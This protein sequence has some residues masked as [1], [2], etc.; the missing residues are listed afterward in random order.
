[1]KIFTIILSLLL[2]AAFM[3]GQSQAQTVAQPKVKSCV[4][5]STSIPLRDIT[6][7]TPL[8]RMDEN[9]PHDDIYEGRE[10]P[11][12]DIALP[13]G[14]DPAWQKDKG[15]VGGKAPTINFEAL[16]NSDNS[17][18]SVRPPD[19]DG[20]VGPNHYFAMCNN[21]F[22]IFDRE[23]NTLLGP[24]GNTTLWDG[25]NGLWTGEPIS[26]PIV[27]YDENA[28]RW[29][30]S[31]FTTSPDTNGDYWILIAISETGDPTGA[32]HQ[33]A[34]DWPSKPDYTKYGIWPDGYYMGCN[35]GTDDVAVFERSRM[36]SGLS[37][38]VVSF[39]N[40]DR[41]DSGF[42]CVMP[43]D[44]DGTFPPTG[45][46]CYFV[47]ISDDA[48]GDYASD[49][50]LVWEFDV[51]WTSPWLSTWSPTP[52]SILTDSFDSEFNPFGV[53]EITQPGTA[54]EVDCIPWILM[55][56]LQFRN[57]GSYWSMVCNHT[58]DVNA[59]NRAGI[60]W[61][62]LRKYTG[63]W[64]IRQQSTF[65]PDSDNR[66]MGSMA[67]NE[68]GDIALG[69]N[70]SSTSTYPSIRYTGRKSGDPLNTLTYLEESIFE[71]TSSQT[72]SR[73]WGDYSMMS[74]DPNDGE[75][76][77]Y[78]SM[79]S[80]SY[81]YT[82]PWITQVAAFSF[83]Y[84]A[85]GATSTSFEHISN[86]S[87]GSIDNNSGSDGYADYTALATN[88]PI[89]SSVS[90]SVT[91]GYPLS[92]NQC[93]IWVD[94]NKDDDFDDTGEQLSVSGTPGTGPYTASITP[95]ASATFGECTMRV[96]VT[97][98][99]APEPCGIISYGE[100][101]DYTINV[102]SAVA[103]VWDGSFNHY[104][105]NANNWSLGRIPIDIDPV[106][107]P[108][109]GLQPVYVDSYGTILYE[110]CASLL[111]ESG[112]TLNFYDMELKVHGN[113]DIYGE[114]GMDQDDAYLTI[115]GNVI[116]RSGSTLDVTQHLC[117]INVYGDWDFKAGANVNP[118]EGFVD[119]K[120]STS[121]YIRCFSDNCSFYNLRVYKSGGAYLGN[122]LQSTEDLVV[123]NL[124]FLV[125]GTH[126][127]TY[128]HN[129]IV[130][131]GTFNYYGTF[132][133]ALSS[134]VGSF[135][136]DGTTTGFND[137]DTG[138]GTFYDVVFS[139][140]NGTNGYDDLL[141][142]ND[143]TIESGYF[144]PQ[145]NAVTLG[146][147]WTTNVG[148]TGFVEDDSRVIFNGSGHQYIYGDENFNILEADMGA[149]LRL[150]NVNTD[151][152]C[153]VYD[154]TS[155]GIDIVAGNFTALDLFDN[156]LFGGF[157]VN[158][159]GTINL[160]N[161]GYVD[162]R[163]E[164]HNFGGTINVSGTISDWPYHGDAEIEMTAGIIDFKTCGITI[165]DNSYDLTNNI[166]GGT[167][168]TSSFFSNYRADV[169]LSSVTI[170]LYGPTDT[171]LTLAGG[172]SIGYLNINKGAVDGLPGLKQTDRSGNPL[173]S[174]GKANN[175]DLW[176]DLVV[177]NNATI[178]AGSLTLNG[179]EAS[180]HQNFNVYGSLI[181]DE[182]SDVLNVGTQIYQ[183]LRFYDGSQTNLTA[184]EI[185]LASWIVVFPGANFSAE[186]SNTIYFDGITS[187]TAGIHVE[188]PGT[189][190][191]NIEFN[192][193]IANSFFYAP[194][195]NNIV[196]DGYFTLHPNVYLQTQ[197][198][199]LFVHG[200]MTDNPGSEIYI[201]FSSKNNAQKQLITSEGSSQNQTGSS[202]NLSA[203]F[204]SEFT[205]NGLLDIGS[206]T[207]VVHGRYAMAS[208]GSMII[209]GGTFISDGPNHPDK[210]WEYIS[211]NLEM[212]D[213]LF[214]ITN[215]SIH[216][217]NTAST[218]VS[219]GILR[220][221][222]AFYAA[223][224]GVFEP[225]GGDV[226]LIGTLPDGAIY[227]NNGNFFYNLVINREPG[228]Y[229]QFNSGDPVTVKNNLTI[230]SGSLKTGSSTMF[231]GGNWV[232]NVGP[233][234]F[235]ENTNV[236]W[237]YGEDYSHILT[238][239]TFY[240]LYIFDMLTDGGAGDGSRFV[241]ETYIEDNVSVNVSNDCIIQGGSLNFG[242]NSVLDIENNLS[243]SSGALM[244][245]PDMT[246]AE[247]FVGGDWYN[248]NLINNTS[249]GFYPGWS[250]LTFDGSSD[251]V[252]YSDADVDLYYNLT[253]NNTATSCLS[254]TN[255]ITSGD[256]HI[257]DGQWL[258]ISN[259]L[260]HKF[261]KDITI[262]ADGALYPQ[263][264]VGFTGSEDAEYISYN[265]GNMFQ[266]NVRIEK[267]TPLVKVNLQNTMFL[268][269]G[270]SL[271]VVEGTLN[272][273]NELVRCTGDVTIMDG[274]T[275]NLSQGAQLDVGDD[276][277]LTVESGGTLNMLGAE[278]NPVKVKT[279][280]VPGSYY[281]EVNEGG[282]I[283]AE[284][285]IFESIKGVYGLHVKAGALID[286][287]HC[288]NHCEFIVGDNSGGSAFLTINNSQE[289]TITSASFPDD[290]SANFNVAKDFDDGHITFVDFT[291]DFS[292]E[293]FDWDP[294]NLIDWYT[295]TLEV[296][297]LVRNV[298]AAA[299]STTFDITTTLG[300][301]VTESVPWLN[302]TPMTGSGNGT[303][304]VNY[305]ENT[306][307]SSRVGSITITA[308]GG[309][310]SQ[311]VMVT[312]ASYPTHSINL[313]EGWSGLS[314]YI[315]PANNDI[316]DVFDPVADD[317]IIAQTMTQMYYPAGPVNTIIDWASQSA[318]KLKMSA[319]ATLPIIGSIETNKTLSV[320]AGWNLIP[321]IC[322]Y[323][324]DAA[325]TL[326]PLYLEIAKDIAGTGV[327][328]PD[329]S[330]NT[331]GNLTPG[332][333]Y[334]VLL[335]S[336]GS[337]TYPPNSA[338]FTPADPFVVKLPE[339]P[340]N[341]IE[342]SSSSHIIAIVADGMQGVISGDVIGVFAPDGKCYGASKVISNAQN[343]ALSAFANDLTTDAKD[344]FNEGEPFS[345]ELYRPESNE[346]YNLEV[347]FNPDMPDGMF[348]A[349]EGLS[350]ISTLKLSS[351]GIGEASVSG[352]SIYPNPTN[353]L[354]R[355]SGIKD[356][357]EIT[358]I[359]S[360]GKIMQVQ[361]T[362]DQN[363]VS[364]DMSAFSKG[365]YQLKLSN[366]N[367][368]LTRKIIKN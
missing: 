103:N 290:A 252:I 7:H 216:F 158:P 46:P 309:A 332:M 190:F 249:T 64:Y 5:H 4:N 152:T 80:G 267:D 149:A 114:V 41:P 47:T 223:D 359:N 135:V 273:N 266:N 168:R 175:V 254:Y 157:W 21:V 84:C 146:G 182:V 241:E 304:N 293:D 132:D 292:G 24:A 173:P 159:N 226:E 199:D 207:V 354:L 263:G 140:T 314:S 307:G 45:T 240:D 195:E 36:L 278:A 227:C 43:A 316:V 320:D 358:I 165:Q 335:N 209:D 297:P 27:L 145:G 349:N 232:N 250:T 143:I 187:T 367:S 191:G 217:N 38:D 48:W 189:T 119:F 346:V 105:H 236:V 353:D 13:K 183:N 174:D 70:V 141:V 312:Q 69:Y 8:P 317:F 108:D 17:P 178:T 247:I 127:L 184:G 246:V 134:A 76:F 355:V 281:F 86:V 81:V 204:D 112:A 51:N 212:T 155:G 98:N 99:T 201:G 131:N 270:A 9:T 344:G 208:S 275:L 302:V 339:H 253:I 106:E 197:L 147:D 318:Y 37:A 26:D 171:D 276:Y 35:T 96:R 66:F 74:I 235:V 31:V 363:E 341:S 188:E 167:I 305:G 251:Q 85:A 356:F 328:W 120:G 151:V 14:P 124:L 261:E 228:N 89:N 55:Y 329:M 200:Q 325:S 338:E 224:A 180:V 243:I 110:E 255:T 82:A 196:I 283:A 129:D 352:I 296:M 274:G 172:S 154:W 115:E 163:G 244:I 126:M 78:I 248:Y 361:P 170:E 11:N 56:R 192:N 58:V 301:T 269:T 34:F 23:G 282:T 87:C 210:G 139:S 321:V 219:G 357:D 265:G 337:F 150:N 238:N 169:D 315:M 29:F 12:R 319:A 279:N 107:I 311:T 215:N 298:S 79:Y 330:I 44:C 295:E 365:I 137:F 364:I 260:D 39:D 83:D 49:R 280:L 73:R 111:L 6:P 345:F 94:W 15:L 59:T 50:L 20:D 360:T 229:S 68:N 287:V 42:H 299:G 10:Y 368:I 113:V 324:V 340:W 63:N 72:D 121:K 33:Y 230:L 128:S 1:M 202:R 245:V 294:H 323:P 61:Y 30:A 54:Q 331:L 130:V 258:T 136:F 156:G 310:P 3:P 164:I 160:T 125:T 104:W 166:T 162:L 262:E 259:L 40:P 16:R 57:F 206:G 186:T 239:E 291:G 343:I 231:V 362:N 90:I 198:A 193:S 225:T 308:T 306:T 181:M 257:I 342:T 19:S 194:L 153:N 242:E 288:F 233:D 116:W 300:W 62:E 60:R 221:A 366:V 351:T 118:T 213:G 322:N 2:F 277:F 284:H 220:S 327:L 272:Q 347:V 22:E 101:E 234:G 97:Y 264:S 91:N 71:G 92:S 122:S 205:Q 218:F 53:G 75:T 268:F 336:G 65:S 133:F 350:A 203:E 256:L 348:F 303:L 93:G 333:A 237:F 77:W 52:Y 222:G 100:V 285:A 313:P 179:L 211:G 123:D 88:V 148:P 286:P 18:W 138:S 142:V 95:P 326:G 144:N 102:S 334:Y 176:S 289:L 185:H 177:E 161:N 28:N 109:V 67:M 117:F 32:Y 271:H 214:E 25:F